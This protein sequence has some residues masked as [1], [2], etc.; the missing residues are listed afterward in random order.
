M[1]K[2]TL[3]IL[4][5]IL[6]TKIFAIQLLIPMDDSQKNHLKAYGIAY[7]VLQNDIEVN[8]LLNYRGGSFMMSAEKEIQDEC[9][10]RGVGFDVIS[11][12]QANLII[13]E[14][15]RPEV[16][17][18]KVKY[19]LSGEREKSRL[20]LNSWFQYFTMWSTILIGRL[21]SKKS[22]LFEILYLQE[23]ELVQWKELNILLGKNP[24]WFV[25]LSGCRIRIL[26]TK[27]HTI[28]HRVQNTLHCI[29]KTMKARRYRT[30]KNTGVVPSTAVMSW[31]AWK[32][33]MKR[34]SG[35]KY[36]STLSST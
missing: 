24:G 6:T 25:G 12:A 11:D 17:M 16:N 13:S 35:L 3:I 27:R 20:H 1:K 4:A 21:T 36:G 9:I 30:K 26:F 7:W 22:K 18:D 33:P 10:I 32:I 5:I 15:V 23:K 34:Y 19:L 8:W 29:W 14:I 28:Y 31:I 2:I